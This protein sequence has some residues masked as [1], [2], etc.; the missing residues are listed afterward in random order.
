MYN[1][2][3]GGGGCD[4]LVGGCAPGAYC[5]VP[6][7]NGTGIRIPIGYRYR[8][9]SLT[10]L[11]NYY[12]YL[13]GSNEDKYDVFYRGSSSWSSSQVSYDWE[14]KHLCVIK[15]EY[16]GR[17]ALQHVT[18]TNASG[19]QTRDDYYCVCQFPGYDKY[20]FPYEQGYP[21]LSEEEAA[22]PLGEVIICANGYWGPGGS[23]GTTC[24][25][26]P[27]TPGGMILSEIFG[28][29]PSTYKK[30]VDAQYTV[31]S[32]GTYYK[33]NRCVDCPAHSSECPVYENST[34]QS[35][36]CTSGYVK[37]PDT[38]AECPA[39]AASCEDGKLTCFASDG[40]GSGG[41][42]VV[43]ND[44][45]TVQCSG[46]PQGARYCDGERFYC[47]GGYFRY[48][49][50]YGSGSCV[51]CSGAG[52]EVCDGD[53][54]YCSTGYYFSDF[55]CNACPVSYGVSGTTRETGLLSISSCYIPAA[56]DMKTAVGTMVC[57]TDAYYVN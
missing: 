32:S 48:Q 28:D 27:T 22:A 45:G 18:K 51:P 47:T 35:F 8:K 17:P 19:V 16:K 13:D 31:C 56:T 41:Y 43:N 49:P 20:D 15:Q 12:N 55:T 38:C 3:S 4:T 10:Q 39:G 36:T 5:V 29:Y 1:P 52:F 50:T 42:Y 11:R 53:M 54:V 14:K 46:C 34:T 6:Q 44:D 30:T 9:G 7:T 26:C 21:R 37:A 33:D 57:D 23:T 25:K 40:S 24:K 2:K